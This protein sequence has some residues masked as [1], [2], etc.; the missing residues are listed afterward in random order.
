MPNAKGSAGLS[1]LLA[2]IIWHLSFGIAPTSGGINLPQRPPRVLIVYN[3][4]VLPP[5]HPDYASENDI[6]E[7]VEE[8]AKVLP[9][10]EFEVERLGYARDPRVLLDKL[11]AWRPDVVF[12][13]FEGEA[14]RTET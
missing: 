7:T 12:N 3:D 6:L 14:D 2:F 9:S 8:V 13:L 5:D 11:R 4:P 10:A 1:S